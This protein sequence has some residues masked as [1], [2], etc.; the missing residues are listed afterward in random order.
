MNATPRAVSASLRALR[1]ANPAADVPFTLAPLPY[2]DDALEPVIS[3]NTLRMHHGKHHQ[4]YVDTLNTLVAG[5]PLAELSL[6]QLMLSTAKS[7]QHAAVFHAAAQ[8]WNHSFY[9]RSLSPVP[10]AVP[11]AL[12]QAINA[13]F[14]SF[15]LFRNR[16]A[17]AAL[18]ASGSGWVW[19]V[20][21]GE[22]LKI[23]HTS[24][25]NN[26]LMYQFRPLLTLDVWEHAYYL[27]YLDRR[28]DYVR[29]VFDRLLNWEF[30]D[31]NFC[32]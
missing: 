23:M 9:W 12:L 15:E 7:P 32:S 1:H 19:L 11:S 17:S 4:G 18:G 10:L 5:L 28:A 16:F 20:L 27:D 26:P 21:E 25:A 31:E 3:A 14:G 13:S 22:K 2:P 24:N 29:F 8:A 6:Q 30:A